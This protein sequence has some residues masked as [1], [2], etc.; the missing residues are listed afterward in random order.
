MLQLLGA[1][2]STSGGVSKSVDLAEKLGFTAMQIFTKNNNRWFQKPLEEKE[3]E[4]FKT[5]LEQS[6]IKLV[7]S[8]DSYLINLCAKDKEI[9]K[10][11]R[12][13][14][15]DELERCELLGIPHLN[16]H[17][18]SHLGAGEEDG[19]K[20]IAESINIAHNKTKGYKVSSML[21]TTAGQGTAIGYRFEQLQQIIEL[22]EQQERMTVC[23]DTAHVFAAGYNIKD[24]K[25]FKK[26]IKELD[27]IIGLGRLKCFHFND[28]KKELGSRVD[29]HE[30]IGKGFIGL[31][32]FS[33]ILNHTQLKKI[34]KI[35]E[36]PKGKE[37]LEDL[38]NLEVIRSLIK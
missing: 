21:E 35:L 26:V 32:G 38:E 14:F 24:S 28:S 31:E 8:H 33:N 15:L 2:T 1:H 36:T 13:A 27:E 34:P 22:V 30:H 10:K 4:S 7:V 18:G 19:I 6:K 11:S 17:P 9:L 25:N 16:F 12:I 23:I 5:K 29:R 37:Q 3:I 20:L